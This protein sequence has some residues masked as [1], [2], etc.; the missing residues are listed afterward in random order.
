MT[1]YVKYSNNYFNLII[2]D[3]TRRL[4]E[5]CSSGVESEKWEQN[6]LKL[7]LNR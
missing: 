7:D 6:I 3:R 5:N 1:K 2:R 4:I